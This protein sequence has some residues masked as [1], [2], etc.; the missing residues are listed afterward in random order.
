MQ[1]AERGGSPRGIEGRALDCLAERATREL[2]EVADA[3][4][5]G[6]HAEERE[7]NENR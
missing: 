1:Y 3:L 7:R 6:D 2:D 5:H 4:V